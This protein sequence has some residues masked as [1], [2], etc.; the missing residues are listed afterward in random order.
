MGESE[1]GTS[2]WLRGEQKYSLPNTNLCLNTESFGRGV[3]GT[4][5][6]GERFSEL[7]NSSNTR[8]DPRETPREKFCGERERNVEDVEKL[9]ICA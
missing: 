4:A 1:D 3:V 8:N 5:G 6:L 7:S 9:H 2:S